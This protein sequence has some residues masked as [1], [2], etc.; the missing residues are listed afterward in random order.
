MRIAVVQL[1]GLGNAILTTPLISALHSLGNEI[2]VIA[3]LAR[4]AEPAFAEWPVVTQLCDHLPEGA[5]PFDLAMWCHPIWGNVDT[6]RALGVIP[7]LFPE[8]CM[9]SGGGEWQ[10]RFLK[11]EIEYLLDMARR[12]GFASAAPPLRL[13]HHPQPEQ[14][15]RIAIGIGYLKDGHWNRKHWGNENYRQLC[16]RLLDNDYRPVLVGDAADWER[17]GR[18]IAQE[19]GVDSLCGLPLEEIIDHMSGCEAFIGNDTGLMHAAAALGRP[20]VA[21]FVA[22]NVVKSRP[23]CD[24]HVVIDGNTGNANDATLAVLSLT[25]ASRGK[26]A[27]FQR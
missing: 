2:T 20:V 23:W 22:S 15:K 6:V 14:P 3:N 18:I 19:A 25:G 10:A 12:F 21:I 26:T 13:R 4:G 1:M 11:H 8:P 9:Q 5:G 27:Q 17:D 24:R 16:R 7:T